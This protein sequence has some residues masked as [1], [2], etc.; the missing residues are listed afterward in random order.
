MSFFNLPNNII[1]LIYKFDNTY[2]C[3]F[4]ENILKYFKLPDFAKKYRWY[5][6]E[7]ILRKEGD[8]YLIDWNKKELKQPVSIELFRFNPNDYNKTFLSL[9]PEFK[10]DFYMLSFEWENELVK[11]MKMKRL[12]N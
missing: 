4:D 7:M 9:H 3:Y 10:N 11:R 2:K 5:T 6:P 12:K 8:I 1:N